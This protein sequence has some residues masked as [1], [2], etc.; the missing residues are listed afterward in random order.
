M[1]LKPGNQPQNDPGHAGWPSKN[2][3]HPS[4]SNRGNNNPRK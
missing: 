2:P 3:N 4:G 1:F